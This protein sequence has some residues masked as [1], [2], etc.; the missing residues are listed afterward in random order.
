MNKIFF[1]ISLSILILTMFN[2]AF[3]ESEDFLIEKYLQD[4]TF[5]NPYKEVKYD[6]T[7]TEKLPIELT[8]TDDISTNDESIYEGRRI[9][10][11][12]KNDVFYNDEI[13]IKKDTKANARIGYIVTNGL[14]GVPDAIYLTDFNIPEI[15]SYKL[16]ANYHKCGNR[17]FYLV[18]PLNLVL[19][20]IPFLNFITCLIRG[21]QAKI[22]SK[23]VI[24]IY[25]YPNWN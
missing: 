2:C 20:E 15:D 19:S 16:V 5:K 3:A 12:V 18:Y 14:N 22:T 7:N 23:D 6:F 17:K 4:K 21:G 11:V 13:I 1:V 8:V 25:Y 9:N 24:T 10:L